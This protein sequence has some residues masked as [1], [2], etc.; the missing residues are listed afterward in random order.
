MVSETG[1]RV[2]ISNSC[3]GPAYPGKG[4]KRAKRNFWGQQV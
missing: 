2:V 1:L 3:K 4:P